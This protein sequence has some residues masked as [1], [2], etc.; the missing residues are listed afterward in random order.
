MLS[1]IVAN[2]FVAT[3]RPSVESSLFSASVFLDVQTENKNPPAKPGV[4]PMRAKPYGASSPS[5]CK[6]DLVS[7]KSC[8]LVPVNGS[9]NS[10]S[11][12]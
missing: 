10:L 3:Y 12:I 1:R 2:L 6:Y 5:R 7:A 11:V 8:Y 4:F 9:L